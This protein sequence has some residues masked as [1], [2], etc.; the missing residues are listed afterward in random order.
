VIRLRGLSVGPSTGERPVHPRC[1]APPVSYRGTPR[2]PLIPSPDGHALAPLPR[3]RGVGVL[4]GGIENPRCTRV[5]VGAR[6]GSSSHM[7]GTGL[8]AS[9]PLLSVVPNRLEVRLPN[10]GS[11]AAA[12]PRP[13]LASDDVCV[14]IFRGGAGAVLCVAIE[15]YEIFPQP[16]AATWISG[17]CCPPASGAP[18]RA[19]GPPSQIR[20]LFS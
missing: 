5:S 13:H 19:S 7:R 6:D 4:F 16:V 1:L 15:S 14:A 20:H 11:I 9:P 10:L 12:C 2:Q 3:S 17:H 18:Y 8:P